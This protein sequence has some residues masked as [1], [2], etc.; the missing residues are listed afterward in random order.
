M[1]FT[2]LTD[3]AL[4]APLLLIGLVAGTIV[5]KVLYRRRSGGGGF[6]Q[7]I[8]TTIIGFLGAVVGVIAGTLLG[9]PG[10]GQLSIMMVGLALGG[11]LVVSLVFSLLTRK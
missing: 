4:L 7:L 9:L 1:D 5:R 2:F 8:Q 10:A 11:T 6:G 3:P